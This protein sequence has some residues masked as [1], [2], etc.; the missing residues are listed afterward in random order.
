[1]ET[2]QKII[3]PNFLK[4]NCRNG[5][6]CA[7]LHAL[8][9]QNKIAFLNY[10][11]ISIP[12]NQ[13]P[14]DLLEDLTS[15]NLIDLSKESKSK[16]CKDF[17]LG[18][19]ND[20]KCKKLHGYSENFLSR[21]KI[22]SHNIPILKLLK[23][24]EEKIISADEKSFKI[25]LIEQD[26]FQCVKTINIQ[27]EFND[28]IKLTNIFYSNGIIF[29][30]ELS[31]YNN[32]GKIAVYFKEG[33][34]NINCDSHSS[35]IND[36]IY[37]INDNL[38]CTFGNLFIEIYKINNKKDNENFS[39]L[40]MIP[41]PFSI[42][43]V[44]FIMDKFLCGMQNGFL[45]ILSNDETGK[46]F[47]KEDTCIQIHNDS[48]NIIL[49]KI[50]NEYTHY[51][52]SGS[53][54]KSVKVFNI[55]KGFIKVAEKNFTVP[56]NN[57]FLSIDF[58]GNDIIFVSLENGN[59]SVLSNSFEVIFDINGFNNVK[60]PRFGINIINPNRSYIEGYNEGNFLL[61]NDGNS[62]ECN[63]WIK[64]ENN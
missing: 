19:C 59:I 37:L 31:T 11:D 45:S 3:C 55:E 29:V 44:L 40:K 47:F 10:E 27:T 33:N 28:K 52:I 58:E 46:N 32:I 25:Y 64:R 26:K 62:I 15:L 34:K 39:L 17:L 22:F 13:K 6:S 41:I 23:I 35:I 5:N 50:V 18:N 57:I 21:I 43:S 54:D 48:V 56:I 60:I 7:L 1:M 16:L 8:T 30:T 51:L 14:R 9:N 4:G 2:N 61:I 42:N 53:K 12:K 63:Q 49:L 20:I 36:L 24:S 38:V